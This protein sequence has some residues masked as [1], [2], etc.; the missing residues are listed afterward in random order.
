MKGRCAQ[1]VS[2]TVK[3][4]EDIKSRRGL[5]RLKKCLKISKSA[6]SSESQYH[7]HRLPGILLI[8]PAMS[9]LLIPLILLILL[10]VLIGN[11]GM[12]GCVGEIIII[13]IIR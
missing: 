12:D 1:I 6:T 9:V 4:F 7:Y 2:R 13:I 5:S 3:S 8:K 10:I 11:L